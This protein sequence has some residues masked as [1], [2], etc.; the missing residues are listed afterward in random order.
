MII[1]LRVVCIVRLTSPELPLMAVQCTGHVIQTRTRDNKNI[2]TGVQLK[3]GQNT[4]VQF[5]G[6]QNTGVQLK[7]GQNTGVQFKGTEV[8]LKRG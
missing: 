2:D 3:E 6:G 5:K 4:G 1:L 7:G 8:Q